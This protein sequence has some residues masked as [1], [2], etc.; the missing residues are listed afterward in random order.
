[1][2]LQWPLITIYV[3]IKHFSWMNKKMDQE[4]LAHTETEHKYIHGRCTSRYKGQSRRPSSTSS[5][6]SSSNNFK[7]RAYCSSLFFLCHTL[8]RKKEI[9]TRTKST[10]NTMRT[11]D[12]VLLLEVAWASAF[13]PFLVFDESS[14]KPEKIQLKK[15]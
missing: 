12:P 4:S 6:S 8:K 3:Y 13:V 14:E 5:S 10:R 1:M 9:T 2:P 7:R 11:V 15:I